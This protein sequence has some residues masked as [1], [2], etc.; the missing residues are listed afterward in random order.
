MYADC[1]QM[2]AVSAPFE[3]LKPMFGQASDP[4]LWNVCSHLWIRDEDEG[5][6]D[7]WCEENQVS[8]VRVTW[9]KEARPSRYVRRRYVRSKPDVQEANQTCENPGHCKQEVENNLNRAEQFQQQGRCVR[10]T[11]GRSGSN[12][13]AFYLCRATSAGLCCTPCWY[14]C[15]SI[16]GGVPVW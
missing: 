2:Y 12:H 1:L 16:K 13:S 4:W 7:D 11:I 3:L 10:T 9:A 6:Q 8:R 14:T 15:V 5:E